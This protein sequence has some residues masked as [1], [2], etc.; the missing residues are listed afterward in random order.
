MVQASGWDAVM[1]VAP[2]AA[3]G[4]V[5]SVWEGAVLVVA[6]ALGLRA[7]PRLSAGARSVVWTAVLLLVAVLPVLT[8]LW[9]PVTGAAAAPVQASAGWALG[10][11]LL[12]AVCSRR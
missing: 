6:V 10:L 3:A 7:L 9:Q 5:A 1:A 11:V 8:V 4:L 12:W 2:V